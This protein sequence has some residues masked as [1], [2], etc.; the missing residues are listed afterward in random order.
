MLSLV[1]SR[2]NLSPSHPS[3]VNH[4]LCLFSFMATA[5]E[6]PLG[7]LPSQGPHQHQ[8]LSNI[9]EIIDVDSFEETPATSQRRR[10]A[11]R[12]RARN[13]PSTQEFISI[14]DSDDDE[15]EIVASRIRSG[16]G[17]STGLYGERHAADEKCLCVRRGR[18]ESKPSQVYFASAAGPQCTS[19]GPSRSTTLHGA[20]VLPNEAAAITSSCHS[21]CGTYG[22][23]EN[24]D[25]ASSWAVECENASHSRTGGAVLAPLAG[26]GPRGCSHLV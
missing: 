24:I 15:V 11:P 1:L 5:I 23:R 25:A 8:Q 18:Q 17:Q 13:E 22:I 19:P 20:Y 16:H 3:T 21:H 6:R 4:F 10:A 12:P 2:D 9:I 7:A 14:S 26:Y